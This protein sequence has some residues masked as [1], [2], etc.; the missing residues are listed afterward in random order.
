[1]NFI[2]QNEE[3]LDKKNNFTIDISE[4][5]TFVS[6]NEYLLSS[7]E[8]KLKEGDITKWEDYEKNLELSNLINDI[9]KKTFFK[10]KFKRLYNFIK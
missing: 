5:K 1:M 3:I 9:K 2:Y 6:G 4:K 7:L 8:L 10:H